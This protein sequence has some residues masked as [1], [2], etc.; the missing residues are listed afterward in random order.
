MTEVCYSVIMRLQ[1][2]QDLH[3]SFPDIDG[4][5][6]MS[7]LDQT[8]IQIR[9]KLPVEGQ[10]VTR[11][12]VENVQRIV[13]LWKLRR[14]QNGTFLLRQPL[15]PS[16]LLQACLPVARR[17]RSARLQHAACGTILPKWFE[18]LWR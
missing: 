3:H 11:Q 8:E 13:T 5:W 17:Q 4:F 15:L 10:P 14:V 1:S 2:L 7:N 16:P 18:R 9:Q 12:Q 6:Q